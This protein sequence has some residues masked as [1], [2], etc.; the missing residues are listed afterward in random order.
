MG[1]P[2]T[3]K[4]S[5]IC[6]AF[7]NICLTPV[8]VA[9]VPIP[10]PSIGQLS[11]VTEQSA[12]VNA[13][14]NPVVIKPSEMPTTTGDAGGVNGGVTSRTFGKKVEFVSA[15]TTVFANGEGIV[16]LFDSTKQNNGNAVGIV[17]GGEATVL[18]GG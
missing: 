17:L 8:G 1:K 14:G 2:I 16:R 5:G 3:T 10:Y 13:G 11:A 6:F 7:P 18:V 9:V 12:D 4:S 15:S